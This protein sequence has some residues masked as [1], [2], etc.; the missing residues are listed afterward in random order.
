MSLLCVINCSLLLSFSLLSL[1]LSHRHVC[2]FVIMP[3]HVCPIYGHVLLI[4]SVLSIPLGFIVH[5]GCCVQKT[6]G[7]VSPG[8][9]KDQAIVQHTLLMRHVCMCLSFCWLSP[10]PALTSPTVTTPH[11]HSVAVLSC[12]SLYVELIFLPLSSVPNKTCDHL[13]PFLFLPH[14]TCLQYLS[15]FSLRLGLKSHDSEHLFNQE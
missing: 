3:H 15:G 8:P 11:A 14:L 1:C 6:N 9:G 2:C 12:N 10:P 5:I 4:C 7:S 13:C